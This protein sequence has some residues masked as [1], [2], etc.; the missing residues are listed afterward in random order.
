MNYKRHYITG[1]DIPN[2]AFFTLCGLSRSQMIE[3]NSNDCIATEYCEITCQECLELVRK[4][5]D[6]PFLKMSEEERLA[7]VG[8]AKS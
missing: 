7:N 4:D 1:E 3:Q 8:G 2:E 5:P 6:Y